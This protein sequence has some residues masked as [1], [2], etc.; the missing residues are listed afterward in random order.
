M[1][2]NTETGFCDLDVDERDWGTYVWP[3]LTGGSRATL[4]CVDDRSI[5]VTR[6][7]LDGGM[8]D[9]PVYGGCALAQIGVGG[10]EHT[11]ER[12]LFHYCC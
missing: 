1:C 3:E 9:R 12:A 5:S 7:C 2:Y 4:T 10:S 6:D 11:H 8:W